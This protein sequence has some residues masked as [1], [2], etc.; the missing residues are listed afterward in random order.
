MDLSLGVL[1][2]QMASYPSLGV[3][4]VLVILV[5]IVSG[6]TDAPN[7]IA[8]AVSTRCMK[9]VTALIAAAIFNFIGVMAIPLV[10]TA[11]AKTMFAM[12]DFSGDTHTA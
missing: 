10:S 3:I 11:V 5:T 4:L 1:L 7:A 2:S 6:A 12:V 8:S 9:P